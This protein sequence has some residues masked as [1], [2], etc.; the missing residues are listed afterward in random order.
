[1][2][3]TLL[4]LTALLLAPRV[5]VS[6]AGERADN[7]GTTTRDVPN[8]KQDCVII[9]QGDSITDGGRQR[10]GMD[11]NH[12]MGQNYAYLIAAEFGEAIPEKNLT[13]I[14]RG[15]S[16]DTVTQLA[17]RWQT[18]TLDLKPD[19]LSILIGINDSFEGR[20]VPVDLFEKTYDTL[21]QQTLAALPNIRIVL[22]EP[23]V[24]PIKGSKEDI[25]KWRDH[26]LEY[27]LVVDKLGAKYH[28]P[29]VHYQAAYDAACKRAPAKH[30]SWD[31]IHL[32]YA[33]HALMAKEWKKTVTAMIAA[34]PQN[35][36]PPAAASQET[37]N[38]KTFIDYF[39]PTPMTGSL[40]KDVWGALAVGPRDPQNGLEDSTM[41][42][43]CY[44]DG[45][46]IKG[47]DGK[48]HLFASR[49]NQGKGH[50]GWS[51]SVAVHAVSDKLYG[52]YV[53]KGPCWPDNQGGKGHNVFPLALPDGRHAIIVSDTRPGDVFVS[54]SLDG[55]WSY[56][57]AI[58]IAPGKYP[59]GLMKNLSVMVRPEGRFEMVP[60]S[61]IIA[62]SDNILGPYTVQGPSAY[63]QAAGCPQDRMEDAVVWQT[64]GVYHIVVNQYTTRKAYHLTSHNGIDGWK[65]AGLAFE[66]SKDFLRYTDGT[67][68]HWNKLERP[69]VYIENGHV[70]AFTFAG[71]DVKKEEDRG[72]DN[73]GSKILVIPFDGTSLD[74]V[75]AGS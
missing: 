44:W 58:K 23:F 19:V 59:F 45:G 16:G 13:F 15:I 61:G 26:V 47:P 52:P 75:S 1:M 34:P 37:K 48:Y 31:G 71:I 63:R 35:A 30:W 28:I 24:V 69:N 12:I 74:V 39:L 10:E 43:W 29:V 56:L 42:Q 17:K 4:L 55:P 64:G 3:P 40:S 20:N 51:G 22:G 66:P 14:D 25:Q 46:I 70:V 49:W 54:P 5:S 18:D 38:P 50:G 73:H 32:T 36:T 9:F 7:T 2:K 41:K 53:D 11:Y 33:G 6:D 67:I 65:F 72:N 27:Q 60:E 68:N 62:L 21:L 57:G 8:F